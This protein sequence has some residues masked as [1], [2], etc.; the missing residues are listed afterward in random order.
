M[1]IP[2]NGNKKLEQVL[3][4]V[5]K[6]IKLNTLWES[7]NTMAVKRLKM[8]DH[9]K[10]HVAIVSNI[11]L[12]L[13]RNLKKSGI[14][15]DSVKDHN[16]EYDDA[17]V[18]VFLASALHD[19]GNAISREDHERMGI[20]LAPPIIEDLLKDIYPER[21]RTIIM[22]EILHAML[23]HDTNAKTHTTEGGLVMIAD[24]LDMEEGRARI[25]FDLGKIDIHSVSAMSIENVN[26]SYSKESPIEIEIIMTNSAGIFQVDYLLKKKIEASGLE[27]Y[28]SV[29][30]RVKDGKEKKII[31]IYKLNNH[32]N[33]ENGD[34]R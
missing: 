17:E 18:I 31:K 20:A 27:R 33:H 6:N 25:P 8:T 4:K 28:V 12:K 15:P 22:T 19:I 5:N 24:G 3:Y 34:Q 10:V 21:E 14:T 7:S 1:N 32:N 13:L 16:L 23:C 29:T 26:L 30:A 9:G 11:A 2:S